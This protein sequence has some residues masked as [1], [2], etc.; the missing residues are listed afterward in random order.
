MNDAPHAAAAKDH[1][2]SSVKRKAYTRAAMFQSG[3]RRQHIDYNLPASP[4]RE[5]IMPSL[6]RVLL[7][8]ALVAL[9]STAASTQAPNGDTFSARAAVTKTIQ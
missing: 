1:S 3:G 8:L 5:P 7:T 6:R 9:V 2:T 4:P